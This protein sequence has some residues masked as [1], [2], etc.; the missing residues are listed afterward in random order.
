MHRAARWTLK[1][2]LGIVAVILLVL[3][4]GLVFLHT[5]TGREVVRDKLEDQLAST[6][7]GDV[8]I[9]KLEGSPLGTYVVKDLAIDGPDGEPAIEIGS[10]SLHLELSGLV[11]QRAVLSKLVIE[12][13]R[14]RAVRLPDGSLS[15][16]HLMKPGPKSAWTVVI[17]RLVVRR[18]QFVLVDEQ[19]VHIDD[20]ELTGALELAG[21]RINANANLRARWRERDVPLRAMFSVKKTAEGVA[22]PALA[23]YAG[24]VSIHAANVEIS[25]AGFGGTGVVRAPRGAVARLVPGVDL[26]GDVE[27]AFEASSPATDGAPTE[28]ALS[29]T[30]AGDAIHGALELWLADRRARGT[31]TARNLRL[32]RLTAGKVRG[33]AG[34]KLELDLR[35]TE[36]RRLP[37][38]TIALEARGRYGELPSTVV[39]VTARSNGRGVRGSV[40]ASNPGVTANL[41]GEI[42]IV[43]E[44]ISLGSAT[45]VARSSNLARATGGLVPVR[46]PIRVD[47]AAHGA[48]V[49]RP[50][51]AVSGTIDGE[52]LSVSPEPGQPAVLEIGTLR[53][54]IDGTHLPSRPFG[55][56]TLRATEVEGDQLAIRELRVDAFDR[57]DG[58]IQA[59]LRTRLRR[60][61]WL[62]E[63]DAS[64]HPGAPTRVELQRHL[65]RAGAGTEWRG[66]S[67]RLAIGP[68]RIEL[69]DLATASK[70]GALRVAGSYQRTGRR[71]GDATAKVDIR[72]LA[73]ANL[74]PRFTGTVTAKVELARRAGVIR[75]G[76]DLTARDVS[77]VRPRPATVPKAAILADAPRAVPAASGAKDRVPRDAR[78][79][80]ADGS[81]RLA[82][83][84]GVAPTPTPKPTGDKP[85]LDAITDRS[86]STPADP[87]GVPAGSASAGTAAEQR[88][89]SP[90][91]DATATIRI[92]GG[93][94]S[95]V[96][97]GGTPAGGTARLGLE[98][99]GPTE[100]TDMAAWQRLGGDA[101]REATVRLT[102][103]ELGGIAGALGVTG[104]YGGTATG[105]LRLANGTPTGALQLRGLATPELRGLG[106]V[107][108]DL[109]VATIGGDIVPTLQVRLDRIGAVTAT[110]EV[111]APDR[112][113]DPAAWQQLGRRA[114][115]RARVRG[116]D[117][118]IDPGRLEQLGIVATARGRVSFDVDVVPERAKL[119]VDARDLRGSPV[120][121]PIDV[122]LRA[123]IADDTIARF[124]V[125][126]E[127]TSMID[128][129]ASLPVSFSELFA[130]PDLATTPL[131]GAARV[132]VGASRLLA[133]FG[134]RDLS[135]GAISGN[136][137]L[138]GTV[139]EPVATASIVGTDIQVPPGGRGRPIQPIQRIALDAVWRDGSAVVLVEGKQPEG[140][141]GLAAVIRPE[142][143]DQ[144]SIRLDARQFDIRPLLVFAPGPAGAASGRLDANLA[145]TGLDPTSMKI[146]GSMT[147]RRGRIPLAPNVG[148]LRRADL[149]LTFRDRVAE[150][151]LR[152]RLG[153]GRVEAKGNASL[154]GSGGLIELTL[155]DVAPIGAVEPEIDADVRI[156]LRRE[157]DERWIADIDV[158]G[159]KVEV[160][161]RTGE[162]LAPAGAPP[163]MVFVTGERLTG[164]PLEKAPPQE[165]VI[166]ANV[167]IAPMRVESEELRGVIKG[168]LE[169]TADADAIGIVGTIEA[170]RGDLDLFGRRYRVERAAVRF[171]GGIDPILDLSLVHDFPEVTT[172]TE[173]RGRLSKPRISM[174]S[175]PAIYSQAQLLGFL[176]G[177]QPTGEPGDAR[178]RAT[179]AGASFLAN[180]IGG[181][182]RRALPIDLDVL[183]YEAATATSSAAI[184]VGTWLRDGL[185]LAYRRRLDARPDENAGEG[186]LEY[187]L[188]RRVVIEAV[189]GD[190]NRD[191][192]DLLW[193]KRY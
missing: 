130:R 23:A 18:S 123:T 170:D 31:V 4:G 54:T 109:R 162:A 22:V 168:K 172:R 112:L 60:D 175:D 85:P 96:A 144:A 192:V 37:V 103:L 146:A 124:D 42:A 193:R 129:T 120:S 110:A 113:F 20:I 71:A 141:L 137:T 25:G 45:L 63:A 43:G 88:R 147:L 94:A 52:R 47:L 35:I 173:V 145:V 83:E 139:G 55:K 2:T 122:Q 81:S 128:G 76:A 148:T 61:P 3:G 135:G 163:D 98:L 34:G 150:V 57:A 56:F 91:I 79:V 117:L 127:G 50:V 181:Y 49:P 157:Q 121:S 89:A 155:R 11:K 97:T 151:V 80:P 19:P 67:G 142:A 116:R 40:A 161:T 138:S 126:T 143:L 176:L 101:I 189:V 6:F 53:A 191:S 99:A 24:R 132:R 46:G 29:G 179:S 51:L 180:Q 65:I 166:V 27:L 165:P 164:R 104:G 92:D 102:G 7:T 174:S 187:W 93:R 131:A 105:E 17:E 82:A 64:I 136:V 90:G 10:L 153:G 78:G 39:E 160:P 38:G 184:T 73:L 14:I 178:D 140:R 114:V 41:A 12:D 66:T 62:I 107:D 86:S 15:L 28:L 108:A 115:R 182:V 183:R 5:D 167:T 169:I 177:G 59:T 186:E 9:G 106:K 156:E 70:D 188:S 185:F 8:R 21:E 133:V 1:I 100:I 171:D 190:R 26:P 74:D 87:T 95:I 72:T 119:V 159:G 84:A 152:G 44:R 33:R 149:D 154:D 48:L 13:A 118:A 68:D 16:Q 30:L 69:R 158:R 58:A 77:L 36:G 32:A 111:R 75:A 125:R 134:R